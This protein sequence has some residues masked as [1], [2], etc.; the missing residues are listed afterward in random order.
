MVKSILKLPK[1]QQRKA[2][3]GLRNQ[4]LLNQKKKTVQ[5][6]KRPDLIKHSKNCNDMVHCLMRNGNFEN[7]QCAK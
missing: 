1:S 2:I 7:V 3:T 5:E 6:G 4:G